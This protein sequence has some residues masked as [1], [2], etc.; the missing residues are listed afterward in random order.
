MLYYMIK[1]I[2]V[3]QLIPIDELNQKQIFELVKKKLCIYILYICIGMYVYYTVLIFVLL[4]F[5]I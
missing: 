1:Q 2:N 3:F 5:N 4:N